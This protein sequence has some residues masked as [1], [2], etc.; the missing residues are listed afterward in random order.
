MS[1]RLL[2]AINARPLVLDAAMGTRLIARGLDLASDDPAL[3]NLSRPEVV[4]E[5]HTL[6]VAAG[7]D[8]I[9]TN[10]FGANARWLAH[11]GH[12]ADAKA[13]N[14][15]AVAIA[16]DMA[17]PGRFVLGSIGPSW[18]SGHA[19]L[20]RDQAETLVGAGV[21]ALLIETHTASEARAALAAI[22]RE[23]T[24][25]ILVTLRGI[26]NPDDLP[27]LADG[28]AD[29]L[30]SNCDTLC[31]GRRAA[32]LVQATVG[33]PGVSKPSG[34]LPGKPVSPRSFAAALP[35]LLSRGVRL[36]GGCCG[37]TEAHVAAIR[38]AL[39]QAVPRRL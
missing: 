26:V 36:F 1:N 16:R 8:A 23:F 4:G 21:D 7:S 10:T 38:R 24:L 29:G 34:G 2:T 17:G 32:G 11:Y 19:G 22:R 30:G 5:V 37:S 3:W 20:V 33:L 39:D 9:V 27:S 6:D 13:I 31:A 14:R 18:S 25:P 15:R 12:E 28:G 35:G